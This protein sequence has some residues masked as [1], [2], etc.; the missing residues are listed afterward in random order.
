MLG[1]ALLSG[2]RVSIP[3]SI[4]VVE[5]L[6]DLQLIPPRPPPT[7]PRPR[8]EAKPRQFAASA[9]KAQPAKLGG[10]PG[11]V[12]AA[13]LPSV[14][15]I[16]LVRP[17]APPSGGGAGTGAATGSGEGGGL[18]GDGT[19]SRNGGTELEQIA[20]EITPRD[21]PRQLGRAGIG[22]RVGL[23][24]SVGVN[25]RVTRCVVTHSSGVPELDSLTCSLIRQRF[26]FRP[27]TDRFGRPV[28]DEVE[29]EHVWDV[30]RD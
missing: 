15:P 6:I 11:P 2:L 17:N 28:A 22:G 23:L 25:G 8:I 18:G 9:P 10:S 1:L 24:F 21:Y 26:V 27:A 20:G 13:A 29:G 14:A 19:G 12:P 30:G 7:A 4:D 3:R 16:V 5:K